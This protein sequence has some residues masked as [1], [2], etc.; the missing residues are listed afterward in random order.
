MT[1]YSISIVFLYL[2]TTLRPTWEKKQ[3]KKTFELK[4]IFRLK[5]K[6]APPGKWSFYICHPVVKKN[7]LFPFQSHRQHYCLKKKGIC[8]KTQWHLPVV[9]GEVTTSHSQCKESRRTVLRKKFL[10]EFSHIKPKIQRSRKTLWICINLTN[11]LL[12]KEEGRM[13]KDKWKRNKHDETY[14]HPLT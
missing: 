5:L 9:R 3:T 12:P 10:Y 6:T 11:N 8:D 13:N 4:S 7:L 2:N 1:V 14:K